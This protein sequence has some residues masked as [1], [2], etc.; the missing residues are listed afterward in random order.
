ME[1]L[2][3]FQWILKLA[4]KPLI[5]ILQTAIVGYVWNSVISDVLGFRHISLLESF[6]LVIFFSLVR[7]AFVAIPNL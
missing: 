4:L 3:F 2:L 7:C 1:Y 5:L 6:K